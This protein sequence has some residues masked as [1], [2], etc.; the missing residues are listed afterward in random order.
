MTFPAGVNMVSTPVDIINNDVVESTEEFFLD[1]EI[2][3]AAADKGVTKGSPDSAT[4]SITD[5]DSECCSNVLCSIEY[6]QC[7]LNLHKFLTKA[8]SCTIFGPIA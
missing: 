2:P 4:V 1:L 8:D 3:A 5:E 6:N 7:I